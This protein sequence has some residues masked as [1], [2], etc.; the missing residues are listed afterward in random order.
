MEAVLKVGIGSHFCGF[1]IDFVRNE[2]V[3]CHILYMHLKSKIL[4]SHCT[5]EGYFKDG[6]PK[7]SNIFLCG[8]ALAFPN[9]K[10]YTTK[11]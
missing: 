1:T 10:N 3:S 5:G 2:V 9:K 7:N 11:Y 6:S 4:N 8:N